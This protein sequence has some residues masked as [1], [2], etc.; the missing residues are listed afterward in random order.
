MS[1]IKYSEDFEKSYKNFIER[2]KM[3]N[4]DIN[5]NEI[6]TRSQYYNTVYYPLYCDGIIKDI[7]II[8]K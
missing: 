6:A 8:N 3:F 1:K 7:G 4:P 2:T 5:Q